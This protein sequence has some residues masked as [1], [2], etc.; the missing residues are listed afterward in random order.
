MPINRSLIIRWYISG[1]DVMPNGSHLKQKRPNGVMKVVN[2]WLSSASGTC[3]RPCLAS[4]K[5]NIW[6]PETFPKTSSTVGR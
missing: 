1:A 2:S 5:E 3:Q 4:S 6:A